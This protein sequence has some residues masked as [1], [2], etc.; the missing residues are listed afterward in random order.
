[1]TYRI[2]SSLAVALL[3]LA[4]GLFY[5][6]A[7]LFSF[8]REA[9]GTSVDVAFLASDLHFEVG[10]H[11]IVVSVVALQ[12]PAGVFDLDER[13]RL[14][15]ND[16]FRTARDPSQ[17]V[18]KEKIDLSVRQYQ[19]TGENTASLGICPL[20]TQRWSA[21]VCRG[22]H[23]GLLSRL[24]K[25]FSLIDRARVEILRNQWTVGL[26]RVYDQIKGFALP[27]GETEVG[28]DKNSQFCTAVVETLPGLLAVWSVW[29]DEE[30]GATAEQM[31][32]S[33]GA[34][35]VQFVAVAAIGFPTKDPTLPLSAAGP[36]SVFKRSG[37]RFA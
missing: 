33:Q 11:R 22:R 15:I 5:P 3:L 18:R 12:Q 10:G 6:V 35:I 28:C 30:L 16:E 37:N 24:P 34:A 2:C 8:G 9:S 23:R 7:A 27:P 19:Y 13:K 20:L 31:A 29:P 36:R 14:D 25:Q 21:M 4:A 26:E 1:M 17:P 32:K